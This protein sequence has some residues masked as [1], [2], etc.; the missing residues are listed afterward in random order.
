MK[1]YTKKIIIV[2]LLIF[3]TMSAF[4]STVSYSAVA[5]E[6]QCT[7]MGAVRPGMRHPCIAGTETLLN[8]VN[9]SNFSD[10][11]ILLIKGIAINLSVSVILAFVLI[12]LKKHVKS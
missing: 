3:G 9:D 7:M 8:L 12:Y 1:K 11:Y 10:F 5:S 2:T 4:I 6:Y